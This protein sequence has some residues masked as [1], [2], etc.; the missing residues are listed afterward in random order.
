MDRVWE[1]V[2]K[3]LDKNQVYKFHESMQ[4]YTEIFTN[5]IIATKDYTYYNLKDVIGDRDL[6]LLIRD[7]DS[8]I[9]VMNRLDYNNPMRKSLMMEWKIKYI[10]KLQTIIKKIKFFSKVTVEKL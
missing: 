10:K 9:V 7:N 2:Q 6:A 4:A 1:R 3:F 8:S 5:I